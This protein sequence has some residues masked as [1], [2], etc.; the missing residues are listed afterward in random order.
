M[1][2]PTCPCLLLQSEYRR[3]LPLYDEMPR[4][5]WIFKHSA[6]NTVVV[7]RTFFTQVW[8][9]SL[10]TWSW[11]VSLVHCAWAGDGAKRPYP[12]Q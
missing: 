4:T 6:Q 11:G 9:C 10:A 5:Q 2:R 7:S 8:V 3:A 12:L 1:L